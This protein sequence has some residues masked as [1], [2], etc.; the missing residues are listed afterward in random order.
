MAMTA[1]AP[2]TLPKGPPNGMLPPV[3]PVQQ[4]VA[5]APQQPVSSI[6][7]P[8][9][10]QAAPATPAAPAAPQAQQPSQASQP[11]QPAVGD[12]ALVSKQLESLLSKDNPLVT[13]ARTSAAQRANAAGLMNSSM[14]MGA[15]EAAAFQA[16]MPVAQQDAQTNANAQRDAAQ[17]Q[18]TT[19][20]DA[21][22]FDQALQRDAK[23]NEFTAG[24]DATL[25]EQSMQ[26][27]T[28]QFQNRLQEMSAQ[29][30]EQL[31]LY[32]A[33][34]GVELSGAYRQAAQSTYDSY[35]SEVTKIQQSDMD[36]D[37]KQAQIATLQGLFESR[38]AY[39][40]ATFSAMPGWSDEWSQI[41]L[42]FG[43]GN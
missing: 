35:V 2:S 28:A 9:G 25:F 11:A 7:P 36:P 18:F 42:E 33:R 13:M 22:L 23:Q 41:A 30:V 14:A 40:N 20:R 29:T 24:R 12:S 43:G 19:Q 5:A 31:K 6:L 4:A 8:V 3:E 10:G 39:L 1:A 38:Q 32:D 26:R 34:N 16:M 27:D 17:N 15:G 37:V 21:T